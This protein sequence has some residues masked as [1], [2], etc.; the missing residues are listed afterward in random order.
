MAVLGQVRER[1]ITGLYR[2]LPVLLYGS[3]P[4]SAVRFGGFEFF[5]K[6][7]ADEKTGTLTPGMRLLCGL[8][9][10]ISEAVLVVTPME[11]VKVCI[12]KTRK[13][14]MKLSFDK[15]KFLVISTPFYT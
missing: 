14:P 8:G 10:G 2:G 12:M 3:I 5:R 6:R 4:K 11:T 9:A 1:G 15:L 13:N 7:A